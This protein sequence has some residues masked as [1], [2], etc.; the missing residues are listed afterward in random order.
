MEGTGM[1]SSAAQA[2]LQYRKRYQICP[3]K[4]KETCWGN[5]LQTGLWFGSA[6]K[7]HQVQSV[8]FMLDA[9]RASWHRW[10]MRHERGGTEKNNSSREERGSC[11]VDITKHS[12][13]SGRKAISQHLNGALFG[14]PGEHGV[15][16]LTPCEIGQLRL[17]LLPPSL[18]LRHRS[19]SVAHI[20]E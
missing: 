2:T 20:R 10:A 9:W 14:T 7:D 5:L 1:T 8:V 3:K 16:C 19:P 12:G 18:P 4:K 13:T 11:Y 17:S 6:S 15:C